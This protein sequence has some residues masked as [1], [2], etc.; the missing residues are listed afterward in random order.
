MKIL[1]Y[2]PLLLF[3]NLLFA[4]ESIVDSMKQKSIK[5]NKEI[6]IDTS[7]QNKNYFEDAS[8][9][10]SN[11]SKSDTGKKDKNKTEKETDWNSI[12]ETIAGALLG[13]LIGWG[14]EIYYFFK[15]SRITGKILSQYEKYSWCR[16]NSATKSIYFLTK[17]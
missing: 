2:L 10:Q 5:S 1:L 6:S 16:F 4:N 7:D 8:N 9:N 13:R 3:A 12:F 11:R 14:R 17:Y 15:G